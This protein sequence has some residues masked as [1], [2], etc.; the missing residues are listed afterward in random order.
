MRKKKGKKSNRNQM[1]S[2]LKAAGFSDDEIKKHYEEKEKKEKAHKALM[3]E[4]TKN[5]PKAR[6]FGGLNTNAM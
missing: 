2:M 4:I 1:I 6:I 5:K 3:K